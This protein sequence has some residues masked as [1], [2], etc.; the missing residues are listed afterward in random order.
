MQSK[1][2]PCPISVSLAAFWTVSSNFA[3]W[4]Y[5]LMLIHFCSVLDTS[6]SWTTSFNYPFIMAL[7][8]KQ[9]T[10]SLW[11][12]SIHLWISFLD[13][14]NEPRWWEGKDQKGLTSFP[15]RIMRDL[16]DVW[17]LIK[18]IKTFLT[19]TFITYFRWIIKL[20][21]INST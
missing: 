14:L 12:F 21:R 10:S 16:N 5:V 18:L 15:Y 3:R 8:I 11:L 7:M 13:S 9:E 20:Y 2:L 6:S 4:C 19:F 1:T 17:Q